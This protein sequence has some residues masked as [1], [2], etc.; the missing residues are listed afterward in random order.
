MKTPAYFSFL[1][2][3][4][5]SFWLPLFYWPLIIQIK[6]IL[7]SYTFFSHLN[8]TCTICLASFNLCDTPDQ[9][10]P[11]LNSASQYKHLKCYRWRTAWHASVQSVTIKTQ[12]AR[13][14]QLTIRCNT[15]RLNQDVVFAVQQSEL[16]VLMKRFDIL[17]SG[18]VEGLGTRLLTASWTSVSSDLHT[19]R[20]FS[21]RLYISWYK[22]LHTA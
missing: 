18:H 8:T 2:P 3:F 20:I 1:K 5:C 9:P 4:F 13:S 7:G 15:H 12:K 11:R 6:H 10:T 22:F 14:L 21:F 19:Q 16:G 17:A